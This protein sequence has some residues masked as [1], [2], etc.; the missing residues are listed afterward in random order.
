MFKSTSLDIDT[1]ALFVRNGVWIVSFFL[2]L[3]VA[4][5]CFAQSKLWKSFAHKKKWSSRIVLFLLLCPLG[6]L[7]FHAVYLLLFFINHL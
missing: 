3:T 7:L 5:V 4:I 6:V 1:V 2:F